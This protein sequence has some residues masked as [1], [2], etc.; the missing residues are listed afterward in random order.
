MG[1]G[2]AL[3]PRE[4]AS[5]CGTVP[6][7]HIV[8]V[9]RTVPVDR[10]VGPGAVGHSP[11]GGAWPAGGGPSAVVLAGGRGRRFGAD[12]VLATVGGVPLLARVVRACHLAG[13]PVVGVACGAP[14]RARSLGGLVRRLGAVALVDRPGGDGPVAGI[15][16]G[17][18]WAAR[19]RPGAPVVVVPADW[20]EP[21]P[22]VIAR[23][24]GAAG[25]A[26]VAV[27]TDG[28]RDI[29]VLAAWATPDLL[30]R[31]ARGVRAPRDITDA[32][33]VE[34]IPFPPPAV[35]DVDR[36]G[37]LPAAPGGR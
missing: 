11:P 34:R 14:A 7:D 21:D 18:R 17:A 31:L 8:S 28:D 26:G 4:P 32:A 25:R 12:K 1:G 35:A 10:T 16:A 5:L 33:G 9:D 6:V 22:A 13:A 15:R 36:P 24:V 19:W 27:A 3:P 2:V 23:L 20:A 37:D 29:P 30:S